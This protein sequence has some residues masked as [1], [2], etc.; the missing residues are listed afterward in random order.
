MGKPSVIKFLPY[1]RRWVKDRS[2]FK[3]CL[4]ARQTGYTFATAYEVVEDCLRHRTDWYYLS[5][6]ENRAKDAMA[7]MQRFAAVLKVAVELLVEDFTWD[8]GKC[9]QLTLVFPNGS[10]IV[11]L[12][13]N[14]DTA[15]GVHGNVVLDEF[16]FHKDATA[17]WRSLYPVLTRGYRVIVLST[18]NGKAGKFYQLWT[19]GGSRWSRHETDI[20]KAVAEGLR[21]DIDELKAGM[22]DPDGWAQEFE[23]KFLDAAHAWIPYEL[24]DAAEDELATIELPAG[25]SPA[26]PLWGGVDIG[27]T[28]GR[29]VIYMFEQIGDVYWTRKMQV[30]HRTPFRDQEHAIDAVLPMC[31]RLCIDKG[32]QGLV[33]YENLERKHGSRIEGIQLNNQIKE[34]LATKLKQAYEDRRLRNP[35]DRELREDV[36]SVKAITTIAGNTRFDAKVDEALG[37]ADRFWAQALALHASSEEVVKAEVHVIERSVTG[38]LHSQ[39]GSLHDDDDEDFEGLEQG[40]IL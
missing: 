23:L 20:Y 27:R 34:S 31:Q 40:V 39:F 36:H 5:T 9:L 1:Q 12:P 14:P 13:A 16:A 8:D 28:K 18:P 35:V 11:G 7:E 25:F 37:H 4:K 22:N 19:H 2:R 10:R 6:N 3:I 21:V 38:S 17:I 33:I 30:M 24:L 32:V 26:G 29:T 15:R